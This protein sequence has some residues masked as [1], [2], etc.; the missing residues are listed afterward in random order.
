MSQTI[1]IAEI[2]GMLKE[3]RGIGL[4]TKLALA[5]RVNRFTEDFYWYH[6]RRNGK[7]LR[8]MRQRFDRLHARIVSA[9]SPDNPGLS[10]RFVRA[11]AALWHAYRDPA[12]YASSVGKNV[13]ARIESAPKE[14]MTEFNSY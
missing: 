13:V 9:L 14:L 12:A 11:R 6:K 10:A 5:Q 3:A 4:W 1:T 2:T 7:T 8:D